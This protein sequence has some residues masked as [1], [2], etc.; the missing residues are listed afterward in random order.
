MVSCCQ[1]RFRE[2]GV[3]CCNF[4][5]SIYFLVLKQPGKAVFLIWPFLN[6]SVSIVV[7][8]TIRSHLMTKPTKWH[9]RPEKT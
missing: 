8:E 1:F 4:V 9:V 6:I 7:V 3:L 2:N 5:F